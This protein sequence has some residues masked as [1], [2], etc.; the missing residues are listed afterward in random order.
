M[1]VSGVANF[2]F[3]VYTLRRTFLFKMHGEACYCNTWYI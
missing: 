3:T 1:S 2:D